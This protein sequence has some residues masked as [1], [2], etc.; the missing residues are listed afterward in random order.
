MSAFWSGW[1]I[2]LTLTN[3]ALL[4]WLLMAN[5]RR[6][7]KGPETDEPKTTGHEYD[8]IEEYDN[9][10]PRWWFWMFIATF[11]FAAGYLVV[12]PGLG[13]WK[14]V[15]FTEYEDTWT[16]VNELRYDQKLAGEEA[17]EFG[18]SYNIMA[19]KSIEELALNQDAMKMSYA[20]FKDNC[21]IC[22]G[23]DGGGNLGFPNLTDKDWLWGGTP[24]KILE[25]IT[26]GRNAAMP[27]WGSVLGEEA[28]VNVSEYVLSLSGAEHDQTKADL[29]QKVFANN[30]VVCH[31]ADAKGN[32]QVG[33]PN[34]T[35]EIWLY[36][37]KPETIRMT[38]RDGRNGVM[39]AHSKTVKP[40]KI[41][42]LAAYVYSL[43]LDAQ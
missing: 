2:V 24:E 18:Q 37:G 35:D 41:H 25:T 3:L 42:L 28:V 8:G 4:F 6:E 38:I 9:P 34:L 15:T 43:S 39:P 26:F 11:I 23:G 19:K 29:G 14:G 12:Y 33:A 13:N 22:H 32:Q 30:C 20:L 31:G 16:S 10:L 7:V 21:A 1:I 40:E 17:D 27:A 5:R 36:G